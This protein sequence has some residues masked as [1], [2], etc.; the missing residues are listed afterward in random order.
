M[1]VNQFKSLESRRRT[2][3]ISRAALAART[4]LS[5]PTLNRI[6]AG[7]GNPTLETLTA[8]SS[9]L[10]VEFRITN[11]IVELTELC[12]A[13]EFRKLM[14]EQK[15]LRLVRMVQGTAALEAQAV[16]QAQEKEMVE[17]TVHELL[18]G[19]ARRLWAS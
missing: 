3:R 12:S 11:Q 8:L 5:V 16:G 6:L 1:V 9:A 14:A 10:G 13:N 2:L 17:R 15:A 18:A 4:G 7:E 19:P